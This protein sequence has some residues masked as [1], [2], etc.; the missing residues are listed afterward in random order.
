MRCGK[1]KG[2]ELGRAS[3]INHWKKQCIYTGKF[4]FAGQRSCEKF[5]ERK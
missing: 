1:C 3:A 5:E 4:V 2:Y